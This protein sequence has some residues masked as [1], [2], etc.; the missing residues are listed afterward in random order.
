ISVKPH[1][2]EYNTEVTTAILVNDIL[3]VGGFLDIEILFVESMV[4]YVVAAD[5]KLLLFDLILDSISKLQKLFITA[6]SLSIVPLKYPY[7][8]GTAKLYFRL[9]KDCQCTAILTCACVIHP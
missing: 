7:Y 6:H 2:L 5:P 1:S 9:D 4:T 3:A 8:K